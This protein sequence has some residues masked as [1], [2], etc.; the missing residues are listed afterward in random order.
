MDAGAAG[1]A[2]RLQLTSSHVGRRRSR[3]LLPCRRHVSVKWS[4]PF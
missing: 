2:R 3:I 4:C 1:W